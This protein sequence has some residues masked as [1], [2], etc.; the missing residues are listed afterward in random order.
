MVDVDF[1]KD[2]IFPKG[3]DSSN[4][5]SLRFPKASRK[6]DGLP[7]A[8]G[9]S[10]GRA[11]ILM[12]DC[13]NKIWNMVRLGMVYCTICYYC[14]LYCDYWDCLIFSLHMTSDAMNIDWADATK[15]IP[16]SVCC[17]ISVFSCFF[18]Y[19][20]SVRLSHAHGKHDLHRRQVHKPICSWA[21]TG[22]KKGDDRAPRL[23]T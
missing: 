7:Q 1:T 14:I 23:G 3:H 20:G 17:G 19:F 9:T 2:F 15:T 10:S 18:F 13:H 22:L 16:N 21:I 4:E 12:A 6:D 11:H 5:Y 8:S